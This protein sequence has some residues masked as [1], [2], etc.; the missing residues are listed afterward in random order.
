MIR[1][2]EQRGHEFYQHG[3]H[4]HAFECGI[5]DLEML[6][7]DRESFHYFNTSRAEIEAHHILEAQI[8]MLEAG[9]KI[10][11]EAFGRD[12]VGFRPG[13]GA[14]CENF[15]KALSVLGYEWVSS[16]IPCMTSWL[17]S[18]EKWEVP[19]IFREGMR[20]APHQLK[21]GVWEYPMAGDYAFHVPQDV[22]KIAAMVDLAEREFEVF[23]E[24]GHPML[25]VSHCFGLEYLGGTGYAVHEKLIPALKNTGRAEFIGM[26]ELTRRYA[27]AP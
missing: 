9:Q 14:Y 27:Q 21:Q 3:F 7:V 16:K 8:R 25:L 18:I 23:S 4:H 10:W 11:R 12:S 26:K 13:W 15:Y 2:A 5:P 24:R 22:P 19:M 20:T 17:W 1:D 6:E